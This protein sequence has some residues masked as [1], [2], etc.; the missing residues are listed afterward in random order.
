ML[1]V[2]LLLFASLAHS[3][4]ATYSRIVKIISHTRCALTA[5]TCQASSSRVKWRREALP[6]VMFLPASLQATVF[7]SL[8]P[9][10]LAT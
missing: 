4:L 7:A 9:C 10:V 2:V 5:V 8:A 1:L 6:I 3:V